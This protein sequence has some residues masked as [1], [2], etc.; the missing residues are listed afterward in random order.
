MAV[1][2][3]ALI[4]FTYAQPFLISTVIIHLTRADS[5]AERND[6]YGLIG[7]TALIYGGIAVCSQRIDR[8]VS[9]Q[10]LTET[11]FRRRTTSISCTE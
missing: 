9:G 6:G 4:A 11:R 10:Q 3:I 2:R 8:R 1:P 5:P 7:A